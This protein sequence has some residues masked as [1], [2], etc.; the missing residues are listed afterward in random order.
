MPTTGETSMLVAV[1]A[2][3]ER[4]RL[5]DALKNMIR[6]PGGTFRVG[7]DKHDPLK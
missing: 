3:A 5:P 4:A 1:D 2:P 6:I 7:S